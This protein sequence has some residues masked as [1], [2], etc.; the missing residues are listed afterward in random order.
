MPVVHEYNVVP[1]LP[2]EL[3]PL[4]EM[5]YNST[6]P[7]TMTSSTRSVASIATFGSNAAT[8]PSP[9]SG[10]SARN[11]STSWRTMRLFWPTSSVCSIPPRLPGGHWFD[12]VYGQ[13]PR[14]TIAYFSAEFGLTEC[15][16]MY[17]G[18]LGVLSGDI[19]SRRQSSDSAVGRRPPVPAGIFPAVP[20]CG[21]LAAAELP[22]E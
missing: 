1:S 17:S 18:G 7:G 9:C 19:S 10:P 5:A 12:T 4:Y 8:I 14:P 22:H 6:G 16:P 11:A 2:P 15:L 20:E 21:R 3:A 13:R